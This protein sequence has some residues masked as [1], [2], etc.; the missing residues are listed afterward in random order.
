M[1]END[2][3][4]ILSKRILLINNLIDTNES[5]VCRIQLENS[6][7]F[8]VDLKSLIRTKRSFVNAFEDR[9]FEEKDNVKTLHFRNYES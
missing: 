7:S 5:K 4:K 9:I 3:I 6:D 2:L 1:F 8:S